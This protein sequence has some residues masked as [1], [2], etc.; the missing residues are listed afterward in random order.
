MPKGSST[1]APPVPPPALFNSAATQHHKEPGSATDSAHPFGHEL[2]QVTELAEEYASTAADKNRAILIRE[3]RDLINSGLKKFTPEDY[4][5]EI[6][7]LF[8]T[9]FGEANLVRSPGPQWI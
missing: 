8:A 4:I 3:E 7:G 1:A 6:Q 9:F 5:A 2:A